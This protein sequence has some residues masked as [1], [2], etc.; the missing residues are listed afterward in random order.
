MFQCVFCKSVSLYK[1]L[2][3]NTSNTFISFYA[4]YHVFGNSIMHFQLTYG[5][6]TFS[7]FQLKCRPFNKKV[8]CILIVM[9]YIQ[10]KEI[11]VKNYDVSEVINILRQFNVIP[12]Q[13]TCRVTCRKSF[14]SFQHFRIMPKII[15]SKQVVFWRRVLSFYFGLIYS[16]RL[17][18]T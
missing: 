5:L 15:Q 9:R 2:L 17:T 12:I 10:Y 14:E 16:R 7:P 11:L 3:R 6:V 1:S 8:V 18:Q 13:C 4:P